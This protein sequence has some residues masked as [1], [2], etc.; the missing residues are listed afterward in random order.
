MHF[1]SMPACLRKHLSME[2]YPLGRQIALKAFLLSRTSLS[3]IIVQHI[4]LFLG[5]DAWETM[6]I[7][8][9]KLGKAALSSYEKTYKTRKHTYTSRYKVHIIITISKHICSL[10][11]FE[12]SLENVMG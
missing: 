1:I 5:C 10:K 11:R 2:K 7:V 4:V 6:K 8:L 3:E 9:R 12:M